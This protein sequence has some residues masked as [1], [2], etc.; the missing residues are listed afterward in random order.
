MSEAAPTRI[1][2][3]FAA[4][5]GVKAV[6][7]ALG[8]VRFVGGAVRDSVIGR[9]I[10]DLD[11][12][13]PLVPDIVIQ[14]L[15]QAGIKVVPTGLSHGTVTAVT[16]A[17]VMEVTTL[18]RDVATDGRHAMIAYTTDWTEDASRRDFTM[19]ALYADAE[20]RLFDP[21]N[22]YA[23]LIA[24][25]VRFIG[26]ARTR[27]AEDYLRI[28]RFF[29][30]HAWYGKGECDERALSACAA[31]QGGLDYLSAERIRAEL[32]K[33]LAAP[34]PVPNI[35]VMERLGILRRLL[36]EPLRVDDLA[37]LVIAEHIADQGDP[38][39]RLAALSGPASVL[40]ECLRLSNA[41]RDRIAATQ[42]LQSVHQFD[43]AALRRLVYAHGLNPVIDRLFLD[44]PKNWRQLIGQLSKWQKPVFPL[45]GEDALKLGLKGRAVG[46]GL[47]HVEDI[48]M[49]SDFAQDRDQLL[50]ILAQQAPAD[51]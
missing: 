44:R 25:R 47:R 28:L 15:R 11:L 14:K 40:V 34:D 19:N 5:P 39:R 51:L 9:P 42:N 20:G 26:D 21:M 46:L 50:E 13:T 45:K 31:G 35:R 43:E 27:I 16:P 6:I 3:P 2:L 32:L 29:R 49:A 30:F 17:R 33:L 12:A 10:G 38:L 36:P 7:A 23:D 4:E 18:R 24:G 8:E 22:G 37:S 48:W 1:Y 41:E